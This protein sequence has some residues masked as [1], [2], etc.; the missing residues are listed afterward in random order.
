M[1]DRAVLHADL[2][3][4]LDPQPLRAPRTPV[5]LGGSSRSDHLRFKRFRGHLRILPDAW[6]ELDEN[7]DYGIR[8]TRQLLIEFIGGEPGEQMR[9]QF[10]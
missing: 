10:R 2:E 4:F 5:D 1:T 8:E 7:T 9:D 3:A 6:R